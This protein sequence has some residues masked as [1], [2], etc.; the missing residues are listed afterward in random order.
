[1]SNEQERTPSR[2]SRTSRT[3]DLPAS[4][5]Q[6]Y[7]TNVEARRLNVIQRVKIA[8]QDDPAMVIFSV[9]TAIFATA[10]LV[11]SLS[12]AGSRRLQNKQNRYWYKEQKK[13]PKL[14]LGPPV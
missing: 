8:F 13:R 10:K 3:P 2:R 12:Q 11:D 14:M 4:E 7:T 1:M 9:S 6:I 5:E